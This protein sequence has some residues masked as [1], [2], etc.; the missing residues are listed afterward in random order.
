M[1]LK[2]RQDEETIGTQRSRPVV[3][4]LFKKDLEEHR[5]QPRVKA[6]LQ[7]VRELR[8]GK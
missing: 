5:E 7:R 4:L 3:P 8:K 6:R 2:P 1:A